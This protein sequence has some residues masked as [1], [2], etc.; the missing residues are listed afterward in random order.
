MSWY[1][2]KKSEKNAEIVRKYFHMYVTS[3]RI[4]ANRG[5]NCSSVEIRHWEREASNSVGE[6][7]WIRIQL[8]CLRYFNANWI[9]FEIWSAL[10]QRRR[11][12]GLLYIISFLSSFFC[13]SPVSNVFT[14]L[15]HPLRQPNPIEHR[16]YIFQ[17]LSTHTY[18]SKAFSKL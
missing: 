6:R 13:F 3:L 17:S 5:V 8:E 11:I 12:Y 14:A 1:S 4:M 2:D 18:T 9:T 15:P 7:R 16:I 10:R